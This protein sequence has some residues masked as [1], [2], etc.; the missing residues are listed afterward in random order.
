LHRFYL[1]RERIASGRVELPEEASRQAATVLRLRPGEQIAVFD[2]SGTEWLVHLDHVS[3]TGTS[4]RVVEVRQ[5]DVEPSVALTLCVA[6]LKAD[7]FEFVLQRCT[8]AGVARFQPFVSERCVAEAPR[9]QKL[10]RWERIVREAA[11]QSGRLVVPPLSPAVS[12]ADLAGRPDIR[13][14]I[15]LWEEE[16][17]RSLRSALTGILPTPLPRRSAVSLII[18]PEGGLEARE[19]KALASAG[20]GVGSLGRRVL[21]AETAALAATVATL[22][23]LGQMGG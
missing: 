20:V 10:A 14:A 12:L 16:R 17:S 15:V 5:P 13:P 1:A 9:G 6:V 7:R 11:E 3:P 8:E 18:G 22:Y 21:R 19:V 4:G 23:H 2:G